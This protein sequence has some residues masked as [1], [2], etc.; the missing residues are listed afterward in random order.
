M[1]EVLIAT[2]VV[3]ATAAASSFFTSKNTGT[4]WYKCIKSSLTPP[5]FVFGLVWPVLYLLLILAY[6]RALKDKDWITIALIAVSCIVQVAWCYLY[7]DKKQVVAAMW[8][9]VLLLALAI[10]IIVKQ[11]S[12]LLVPYAA[13]LAF[14]ALLNYK[15]IE[16]VNICREIM[17]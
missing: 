13:W 12:A 14:A 10:A 9:I 17:F 2:I 15:S 8:T 6:V 1:L 4:E 16:N 7:F 5:G 11:R 3:V